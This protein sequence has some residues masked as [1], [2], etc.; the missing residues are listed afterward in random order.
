MVKPKAKPWEREAFRHW[1]ARGLIPT[2]CV[3]GR[4]VY[5]TKGNN[6]LL[7]TKRGVPYIIH[8]DCATAR[9]Y[10]RF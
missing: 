10:G 8:N 7:I 2:C 6:A 1:E 3:C 9:I 4:S 5:D